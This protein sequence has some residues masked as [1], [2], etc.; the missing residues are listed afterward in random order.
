MRLKNKMKVKSDN[1]KHSYKEECEFCIEFKSEVVPFW[2][3]N[4]KKG[5]KKIK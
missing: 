5:G 3:E 4:L 2:K 1:C